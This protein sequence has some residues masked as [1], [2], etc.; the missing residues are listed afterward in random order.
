MICTSSLNH[1]QYTLNHAKFLPPFHRILRTFLLRIFRRHYHCRHHR[2]LNFPSTDRAFRFMLHIESQ[3][4]LLSWQPLSDLGPAEVEVVFGTPSRHC[5]GSGICLIAKRSA[6]R[7]KIDC[8]HAPALL[9]VMRQRQLLLLSFPMALTQDARA[10]D[11]LNQPLLQLEESVRFPTHLSRIWQMT[12]QY[13]LPG[14]YPVTFATDSR[15]L[16]LR[17]GF[18]S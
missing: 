17:L 3:A 2:Y 14:Q 15:V 12:G 16:C 8:P 13:I 9:S 5:I 18:R 7:G 4:V 6:A 11:L 1:H 10:R